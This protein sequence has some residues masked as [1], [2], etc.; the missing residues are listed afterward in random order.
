MAAPP[1]LIT[2]SVERMLN[3]FREIEAQYKMSGH[4][5]WKQHSDYFRWWMNNYLQWA[6]GTVSANSQ[7]INRFVS[8]YSRT[9]PELV[10]MQA[11]LQTIKG[12]GP[13]LEDTYRTDKEAAETSPR[14]FSPYY[15][16]GGVILGV[17]ALVAVLS[18]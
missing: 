7:Y 16:K 15:I 13:K 5:Y 11:K 12:Q 9:N 4:P 10:A 6:E 8:D 18:L 3:Q 17:A 2:P 14:D 1:T